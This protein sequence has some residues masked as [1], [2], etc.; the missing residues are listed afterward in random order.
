MRIKKD[1]V[2]KVLDKL[3]EGYFPEPC[4]T[5]KLSKA[6]GMAR[7]HAV[8][9]VVEAVVVYLE[10]KGLVKVTSQKGCRITALGIDKLEGESL[11]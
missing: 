10:D 1:L 8:A 7:E 3:Y 4:H 2:R 9:L 11:I 6:L 5:D